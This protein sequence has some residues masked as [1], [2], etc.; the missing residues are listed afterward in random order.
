[1]P[2]LPSKRRAVA[3]L[4]CGVV[5]LVSVLAASC[6][7]AAEKQPN[8]P[9]QTQA[10]VTPA[11]GQA[12]GQGALAE[13]RILMR[14]ILE[15]E[16]ARVI[17]VVWEPKASVPPIAQEGGE[18]LGVVGV[19]LYGGTLEYT[20]AKGKKTLQERKRGQVFWQ[21]GNTK[22]EARQN[23]GQTKIDVVQVRLKKAPLTKQYAGPVAVTKTVLNNPY[24]AAFDFVL[25]PGATLPLHKYAPRVWVILDGGNLR[26]A[27]RAGKSQFAEFGPGQVVWLPAAE[28]AFENTGKNQVHVISIELK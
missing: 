23:T 11:A 26:A 21:G 3:A 13:A 8:P 9:A 5:V 17:E 6:K 18:T 4:L 16:R 2:L 25:A 24:L 12:A 15:N 7:R 27:D 1:M 20:G 10:P 19:T 22:L 14:P 28:Q